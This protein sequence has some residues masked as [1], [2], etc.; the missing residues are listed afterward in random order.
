MP[1]NSE[2]LQEFANMGEQ[3]NG[4]S[5]GGANSSSPFV[6]NPGNGQFTQ[7]PGFLNALQALELRMQSDPAF[8][9]DLANMKQMA[10]VIPPDQLAN[11]RLPD[12]STPPVGTT[13]A[14]LQD[15]GAIQISQPQQQSVQLQNAQSSLGAATGASNN[16]ATGTVALGDILSKIGLGSLAN[17]LPGY[18]E[19]QQA[20]GSLGQN[21]FTAGAAPIFGNGGVTPNQSQGSPYDTYMQNLQRTLQGNAHPNIQPAAIP[22]AALQPMQPQNTNPYSGTANP[23]VS[24]AQLGATARQSQNIP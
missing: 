2:Q 19:Y 15:L 10:T 16:V 14:H 1:N 24:G 13:Y 22:S 6:I 5:G 12:G 7:N 21:P 18:S 23:I 20:I 3:L 17:M 9:A 4:A 8:A 11:F